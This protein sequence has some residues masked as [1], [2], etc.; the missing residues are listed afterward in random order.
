[1]KTTH[2]PDTLTQTSLAEMASFKGR[3]CPL[4]QTTHRRHPNNQQEPIRFR[5]LVK[6]LE[7]SLPQPHAAVAVKALVEPFEAHAQNHDFW[8]YTQ[9]GLAVLG[10][11]DLFRM[12]LMVD[13][14]S[15]MHDDLRHG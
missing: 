4:Y 6:A 3:P 10:A 2:T 8:N 15:L 13:P 9:G 11:P 1:M 12:F 14:H 7:T 5:H